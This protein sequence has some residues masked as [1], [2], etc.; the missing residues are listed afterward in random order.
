MNGPDCDRRR[1]RSSF[2]KRAI[3]LQLQ[4]VADCGNF[5]SLVLADELGMVVAATGDRDRA[6]YL[7]AIL[8]RLMDG[9]DVWQGEVSNRK[10]RLE[11]SVAQVDVEY[12]SF[13]LTAVGEWK[14]DTLQ[15]LA[16]TGQGI[17]RILN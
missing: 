17:R 1:N 4:A 9:K 16:Y 10:E 7:A 2:Y 11:V 8:P 15:D 3:E 6:E 12:G 5:D 14:S 13:Y